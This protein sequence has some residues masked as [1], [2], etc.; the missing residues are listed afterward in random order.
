[1]SKL[2][3]V[4]KTAINKYYNTVVRHLQRKRL[5]SRAIKQ[6]GS[7]GVWQAVKKILEICYEK[8]LDPETLDWGSM[9]EKITDYES[10]DSFIEG[11][12]KDGYLAPK[13]L[14]EE[15]AEELGRYYDELHLQSLREE[16]SQYGYDIIKAKD[17]K[18][19]DR[20][21]SEIEKYKKEIRRQKAIIESLEKKL[22]QIKTKPTKKVEKPKPPKEELKTELNRLWD[23]FIEARM[24]MD[25]SRARRLL[26]KFAELRRTVY[27]SAKREE[28]RRRRRQLEARIAEW[29]RKYQNVERGEAY[30][31]AER[32]ML[33]WMREFLIP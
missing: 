20:L 14:T 27:G 7:V 26:E 32:E 13:P 5:W 33:E 16:L 25:Y 9:F 17:K 28:Y 31:L 15:E 22:Q 4:S 12:V 29:K 19:I 18:R 1:V 24:A 2:T 6:F 21:Y 8:G 10:V 30:A 3:K 23:Q 11:L